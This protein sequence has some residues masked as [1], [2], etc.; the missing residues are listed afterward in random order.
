[1]EIDKD[2]RSG[3]YTDLAMVILF[4]VIGMAGYVWT[5]WRKIKLNGKQQHITTAAD[6]QNPAAQEQASTDVNDHM[7]NK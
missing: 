1:M 7:E 6:D 4:A 2:F 5:L 3:F